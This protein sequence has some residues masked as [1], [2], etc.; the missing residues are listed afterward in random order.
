MKKQ[1]VILSILLLTFAVNAQVLKSIQ[2]KADYSMPLS[3]RINVENIDA[4]GGMIKVNFNL[5]ENL[6]VSLS[7]GYKLYSI[8]QTNQLFGWGWNFWNDRYYNK[9][10]SD[11]QADPNLSVEIG[12]VQKMDVIPAVLTFNYDFNILENFTATPIIGGGVYFFTK[13]LYAKETW[14]K[15][16]PAENYSFTYSFRNFAPDKQGN[17]FIL[18]GGLD[19]NYFITDGFGIGGGILYSQILSSDKMGFSEF[20]FENEISFKLGLTINY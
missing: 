18:M 16:Y 17:P 3:K 12:S 19:L 7:G 5:Y 2:I 10:V 13:R 11:L 1:I 8:S 14:T 9:I 4:V 6:S 20:P 15:Q